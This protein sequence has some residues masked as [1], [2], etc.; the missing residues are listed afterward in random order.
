VIFTIVVLRMTKFK[1]DGFGFRSIAKGSETSWGYIESSKD[2]AQVFADRLARRQGK[3][4][5]ATVTIN[6]WSADGKSSQYQ[7]AIIAPSGAF[8]NVWLHI[9]EVE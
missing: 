9:Q 1:C 3:N 4:Y 7:A 2:A 8:E 5:R 6:S